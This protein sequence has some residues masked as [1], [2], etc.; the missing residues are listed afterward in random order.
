M[1]AWARP[2][3]SS[4][5]RPTRFGGGRRTGGSPPTGPPV[6]SGSSPSPRSAAC[7]RNVGPHPSPRPADRAGLGPQSLPGIVTR[8]ERDGLVAVVE[9]LAG[10]HRVV[11]LMTA[12]AVDEMDLREGDEAIGVVKATNVIV[13][14]PAAREPRG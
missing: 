9:I 10:P 2:P 4:A 12:E 1:C 13:E 6:A 11:S 14:A 7:W 8:I 3:S 5:C